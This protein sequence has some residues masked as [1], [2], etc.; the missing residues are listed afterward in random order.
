VEP[1]KVIGLLSNF[2]SKELR[3]WAELSVLAG[4]HKAVSKSPVSR[5]RSGGGSGGQTSALLGCFN[6]N[7]PFP[8]KPWIGHP[9]RQSH[10]SPSLQPLVQPACAS[11]RLYPQSSI[12]RCQT[13]STVS[14]FVMSSTDPLHEISFPMY[15]LHTGFATPHAA[16]K[17]Q[18]VPASRGAWGGSRELRVCSMG[19]SLT[20]LWC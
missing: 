8:L 2:R 11:M 14:D 6:F 12:P 15:L 19:I 5:R 3:P 13:V 7:G 20:L 16:S 9:A 1:Q 18:V 10:A 4:L 17:V